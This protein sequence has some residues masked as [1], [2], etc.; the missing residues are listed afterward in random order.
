MQDIEKI[1]DELL[2]QELRPNTRDDLAVW[3]KENATGTLAADDARYIRA[4]YARVI[5]GGAP[6]PGETHAG[7]PSGGKAVSDS[8]ALQAALAEARRREEA[9]IAERDRLQREVAALRQELEA[10]KAAKR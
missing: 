2:K 1:I 6:A 4:L 8:D 10:L 9:L 3:R 5:G 7:E